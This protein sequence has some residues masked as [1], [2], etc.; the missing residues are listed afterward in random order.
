M[1]GLSD[2]AY[3]APANW[4]HHNLSM[5]ERFTINLQEAFPYKV[6]QADIAV[7]VTYKPWLFPFTATKRFRFV[8]YMNG[9]QIH[10]GSWP[11]G[12]P[13]PKY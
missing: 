5:D 7:V 13:Q 11:L 12:D 4:Q 1:P 3:I 9:T 10:W 8:T 6:D 2:L